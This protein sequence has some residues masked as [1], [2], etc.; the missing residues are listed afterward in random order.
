MKNFEEN[1]RAL[2]AENTTNL[3]EMR[4][5]RNTINSYVMHVAHTI[6]RETPLPWSNA[7]RLA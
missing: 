1:N 5:L 7:V 2:V 6:A 4:T 3:K